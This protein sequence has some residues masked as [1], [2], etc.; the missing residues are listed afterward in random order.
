ML[1]LA[2][3]AKIYFLGHEIQASGSFTYRAEGT[4]TEWTPTGIMMFS[5]QIVDETNN[6][7]NAATGIFTATNSGMY[8]FAFHG[9]SSGL[10]IF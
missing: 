8:Y 10:N 4:T 5:N 1:E 9:L 2:V 7:Y 6:Q 3:H